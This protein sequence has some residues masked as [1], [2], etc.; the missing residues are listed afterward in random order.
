MNLIPQ[1][2]PVVSPHPQCDQSTLIVV[3]GSKPKLQ[4]QQ[5]QQGYDG[6][7]FPQYE[8][9]INHKGIQEKTLL[10]SMSVSKTC[11]PTENQGVSTKIN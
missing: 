4:K 3:G 1:S 8:E 5:V 6:A 10:P 7:K 9:R 2:Q 11:L